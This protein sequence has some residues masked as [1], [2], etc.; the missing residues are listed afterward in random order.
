M[1]WILQDRFFPVLSWKVTLGVDVRSQEHKCL[2]FLKPVNLL[3]LFLVAT[4]DGSMVT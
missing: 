3:A 4:N 2:L 1:D